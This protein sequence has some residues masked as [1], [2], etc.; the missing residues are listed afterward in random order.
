VIWSHEILL[1]VVCV[2]VSCCFIILVAVGRRIVVAPVFL[3]A[4]SIPLDK[5]VCVVVS[6]GCWSIVG[7][8]RDILAAAGC[9]VAHA[10]ALQYDY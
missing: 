1:F 6:L 9:C 2:V 10:W 3:V 7:G 5:V 4:F 8:A